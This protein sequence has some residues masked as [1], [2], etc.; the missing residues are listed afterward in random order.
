MI[1]IFWQIVLVSAAGF[2][3]IAPSSSALIQHL[4]IEMYRLTWHRASE[5]ASDVPSCVHC[6]ASARQG[7]CFKRKFFYWV[8]VI[9]TTIYLQ[10]VH[11]HLSFFRVS[12][13]YSYEQVD[14]LIKV[15]LLQSS[16]FV[17]CSLLIVIRRKAV[18]AAGTASGRAKPPGVWPGGNGSQC[19]MS[20]KF[21][22]S[23]MVECL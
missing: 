22:G 4:G 3:T 15:V 16:T 10:Y 1:V 14:S 5:S 17:V 8:I 18:H 20:F 19:S 7:V 13:C 9:C 11:L 12:W 21:C 6:K 2:S 23:V